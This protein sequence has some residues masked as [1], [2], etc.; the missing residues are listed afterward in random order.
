MLVLLGDAVT[1][2]LPA[3]PQLGLPVGA[4]VTQVVAVAITLW[5]FVGLGEELAFRG[6][7]QNKPVGTSPPSSRDRVPNAV[8]T[9]W[10]PE[11]QE[12]ASNARRESCAVYGS[13]V[14]E[15][16]LVTQP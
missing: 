13:R 7:L 14:S 2:G 15:T 9:K 8:H 3:D 6:Y 5:L 12:I 10:I 1:F 16:E 11:K 4:P